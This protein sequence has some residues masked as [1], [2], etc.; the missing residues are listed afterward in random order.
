M[1]AQNWIK[2]SKQD[3]LRHRFRVS[4]QINSLSSNTFVSLV[5]KEAKYFT[6]EFGS[7]NSNPDLVSWSLNSFLPSLSA[8]NS[9]LG[10]KTEAAIETF[11]FS[12][13]DKTDPSWDD[14]N[15]NDIVILNTSFVAN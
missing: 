7:I 2:R 8:T 3:N 15:C 9:S 12:T 6:I 11:K 14:S 10:W 1:L 4:R 5:F 13:R